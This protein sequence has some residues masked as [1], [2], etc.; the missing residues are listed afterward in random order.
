MDTP[1]QKRFTTLVDKLHISKG[2]VVSWT[3]KPEDTGKSGQ[4]LC[5]IGTGS[6]FY[7]PDELQES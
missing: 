7:K 2:T 5:N 3:G 6:L 4:F 1:T